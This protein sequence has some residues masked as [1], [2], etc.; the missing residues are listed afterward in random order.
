MLKVASEEWLR[1]RVDGGRVGEEGKT[2]RTRA[3]MR[4]TCQLLLF[5]PTSNGEDKD[6]SFILLLE[7]VGI[8]WNESVCGMH[9]ND[10]HE[11]MGINWNKNTL[12]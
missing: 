4:S 12:L 1:A 2:E 8:N 5:N 9:Y 10:A 6:P 3:A 7:L 11:L